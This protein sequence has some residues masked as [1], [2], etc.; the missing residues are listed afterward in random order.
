FAT[1]GP[2]ISVLTANEH[3][4]RPDIAL[5]PDTQQYFVVFQGDDPASSSLALFGRMLSASDPTQMSSLMYLVKGGFPVEAAVT[6]L[7]AI[8]RFAAFWRQ[9]G[10]VVGRLYVPG[11]GAAEGT[12]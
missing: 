12:I 6:Y 1:L 4:G 7:P 8:G 3:Q 2:V 9:S 11:T 10:D 5:D